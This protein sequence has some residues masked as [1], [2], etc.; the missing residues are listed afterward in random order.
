MLVNGPPVNFDG[1]DYEMTK[2]TYTWKA[3][4]EI[5]EGPKARLKVVPFGR[6]AKGVWRGSVFVPDIGQ[7]FS[8]TITTLDDRRMEGKGCLTGRIMC[9]SQIWTKVN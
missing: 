5:I 6:I 3:N 9:K 4:A 2:D 1:S 7:T 8:G